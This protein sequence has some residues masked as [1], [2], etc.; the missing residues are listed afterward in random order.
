MDRPINLTAP[1]GYHLELSLP[2]PGDYHVI[3]HCF[4]SFSGILVCMLSIYISF[5]VFCLMPVVPK[6]EDD[7]K[8]PVT[9]KMLNEEV[10][11]CLTE[12]HIISLFEQPNTFVSEDADDAEA[13][14]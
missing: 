10:D 13:Q 6:Q 4:K 11:I 8:Q 3:Y 5:S 12:T 2:P 9:E 7:L 14:K 1:R